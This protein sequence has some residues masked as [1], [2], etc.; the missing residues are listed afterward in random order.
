MLRGLSLVAGKRGLLSGCGAWASHCGGF[1][2]CRAPALGCAGASVDTA[3]GLYL[4]PRLNRCGA[5][6]LVTLRH[7]GS[8]WARDRIHDSCIG[9]QI[10]YL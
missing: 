1:S 6:S 10:L 5:L 3:P 7:V 2:G 4:E 9:R 8:S